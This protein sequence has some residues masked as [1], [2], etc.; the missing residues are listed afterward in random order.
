MAAILPPPCGS[1]VIG[2]LKGIDHTIVGTDDLE[3]AR[4]SWERLGFQLTPRG[5]HKGWGTGNYCAMFASDYV[6]LLGSV[7]PSQ[8]DNGLADM[9]AAHGPG[10]L[11]FSLAA[12][13]AAEAASWLGR[14][15]M[16]HAVK[17]LS[18]FIELPGG[19]VEPH[20]ALAMPERAYAGGLKPFVTEHLARETVW[21]PAWCV[22]PNTAIGI[23]SVTC[24]AEDPLALIEPFEAIF[25]LGSATATDETVAL[26]FG[27]G[28]GFLLVV[29]PA[30][31]AFMHPAIASD[32]PVRAGYA[33]MGIRVADIGACEAALADGGIEFERDRLHTLHVAPSEADGVALAFSA[34]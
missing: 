29:R 2:P 3:G 21:Q 14:R 8:F 27:R 16:P 34:G 5:R 13:S 12:D 1:L 24:V 32:A 9:L 31:L 33:G 18:R 17:Q 11:G 6:E 4:R 22:H 26:R 28:G 25:G 30:D 15:G 19:N 20:F 10:L 7:D 23:S